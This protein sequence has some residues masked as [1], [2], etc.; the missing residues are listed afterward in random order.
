MKDKKENGMSEIVKTVTV[1]IMDGVALFGIY[2]VFYGHLSP[3]GGFAGGLITAF[4]FILMF[5]SH[6]RQEAVKILPYH[7]LKKANLFS[8]AGLIILFLL[9]L[10]GPFINTGLPEGTEFR[11]LSGGLILPFNLLIWM[12]V[13]AGIFL[14][15]A[16]LSTFREKDDE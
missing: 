1:V 16:A 4:L 10:Y 13:G 12:K 7:L 5:L 8:L 2:I 15:F 14:V 6:G 3:G 11:L 9:A